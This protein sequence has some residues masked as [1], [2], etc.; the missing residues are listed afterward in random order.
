MPASNLRKLCWLW[1]VFFT[2]SCA[3]D[4]VIR[5]Q[6]ARVEKAYAGVSRGERNFNPA[7]HKATREDEMK[8]PFYSLWMPHTDSEKGEV[9]SGL[10]IL[11][12]NG[13]QERAAR[14][15]ARLAREY[16][17]NEAYLE[18]APRYKL[19]VPS[20]LRATNPYLLW[21]YGTAVPE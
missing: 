9:D 20:D 14:T 19:P 13:Q 11:V 7:L 16:G 5:E 4:P 1:P 10:R 3:H 12:N 15:L 17:I 21:K 8:K 2:A 6:T 18:Q